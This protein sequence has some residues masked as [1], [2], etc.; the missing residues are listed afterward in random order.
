MDDNGREFA[1]V[2]FGPIFLFL[3]ALGAFLVW[4]LSKV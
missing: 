2:F 1:R 3:F 4:G